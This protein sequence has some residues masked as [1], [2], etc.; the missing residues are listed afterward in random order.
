[1]DCWPRK[2]YRLMI[3]RCSVIDMEVYY[4]CVAQGIYD[5]LSP[6]ALEAVA[7]GDPDRPLFGNDL[8]TLTN[9]SDSCIGEIL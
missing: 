6:V 8:T 9:V 1:M 5:D 3:S 2:A 4:E 7:S